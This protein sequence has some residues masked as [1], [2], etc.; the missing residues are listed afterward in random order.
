VGVD[1]TALTAA[2]HWSLAVVGE[3]SSQPATEPALSM[4][5]GLVLLAD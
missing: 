4:L 2:V 5:A 1:F 3:A